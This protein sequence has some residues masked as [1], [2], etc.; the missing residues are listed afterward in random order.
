MAAAKAIDVQSP[1]A[2]IP[3]DALREGALTVVRTLRAAGFQALFAGGCVR[4]RELG[5]APK[6]YD[7]ATSATPE[8]VIGLFDKSI[9]VG[10]QFGVVRVI[11]AGHEYEVAT[12]RAEADY[13]DGRR[14]N[15]V[16]WADAEADVLRRDFTINGLLEDPLAPGG[17]EVLDFVGGRADLAGR[18]IRA[19]GDARARFLEDHLRLLRCVR[20]AARMQ[21]A[22]DPTTYAAVCEL[23]PLVTRV[24]PERIGDE[25]DRIF[26]QGHQANGFMHLH[27]SGLCAEVLPEV[28][29]LAERV[30]DRLLHLGGCEPMLGW[31]V[32][33]FDSAHSIEAIAV[34]LRWSRAKA[35]DVAEA[36][37]TAHEIAR[38]SALDLASQKRAGRRPT[39][40]AALTIAGSAGHRHEELRARAQVSGWSEQDL[41][42]APLLTG[43]DLK[44]A[45]HN[46]GPRF[47]HAL[48]ALET[49]QLDGRATTLEAAW[50]IVN[51]ALAT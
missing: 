50:A 37:A 49:A 4:D 14:P 38:W 24:S 21:F 6:D 16:R 9:P 20:F 28:V 25:L 36:V 30:Q 46:A 5:L 1:P 11:V 47:K 7:I 19:I 23:V 39:F 40:G 13:S 41:R 42:P 43:N 29:D 12:F 3:S 10:V 31:G 33:L 34:R 35:R 45:G 18:I 32:V 44:R 17:A 2:W 51:V 48:A 8:A 27:A 26:S 15:E 22:I